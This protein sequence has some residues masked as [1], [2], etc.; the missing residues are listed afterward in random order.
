MTIT[1]FLNPSE[2][3]KEQRHLHCLSTADSPRCCLPQVP[4]PASPVSLPLLLLPHG[5][6]CGLSCALGLEECVPLYC[7]MK[8]SGGL[9]LHVHNHQIV[10]NWDLCHC[11]Y[12]HGTWEEIRGYNQL[13]RL[14]FWAGKKLIYRAQLSRQ[15]QFLASLL[16][17]LHHWW[18]YEGRF[19]SPRHG[20]YHR[21]FQ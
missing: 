14:H 21:A 5:R 10:L 6:L 8:P 9:Q 2:A 20:F 16:Q 17:Y 3:A 18:A 19:A 12:W 11:N 4:L 1:V 13:L 15:F 7:T